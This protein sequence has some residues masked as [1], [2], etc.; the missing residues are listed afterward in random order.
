MLGSGTAYRAALALL[1]LVVL[2]GTLL[3]TATALTPKRR[4]ASSAV[5]LEAFPNPAQT[6][7]LITIRGQLTGEG[8]PLARENVQLEFSTEGSTWTSI[9]SAATGTDGRF[10]V[11]WKP[12]SQDQ[13]YLRAT[14]AGNKKYNSSISNTILEQINIAPPPPASAKYVGVNYV[15]KYNLYDTPA[16]ILNRDF[17]KFQADGIN[18]IVIVVYWSRLESARGI[19]NQAFVNDVIRVANIANSYGI[20]VMIDF[21]TLVGDDSAWSNPDY[22]GVGMNLITNP[23]IATAYIATVSWAVIQLKSVPNIWAYSVLNE[24]WSSPADWIKLIVD[25]SKAVKSVDNR[26]VTVRFV[27]PL[28]E[29]DFRWDS[30]LLAAVDFISLNAYISHE[31]VDD[32]YWNTWDEYKTALASTTQK[33]AALGKQIVI[34]EFGYADPNDMLQADY[35]R[36]YTEIFKSTRNLIGWLSWG[37]D[38]GD[39]LS[40]QAIGDYAIAAL[41]TGTPRPAYVVLVQNK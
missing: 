7:D 25:L 38:C 5:T 22:V 34:T 12:I 29:R 15:S 33:A 21:H 18:S 28:F 30:T 41:V 4:L 31:G 2:T 10:S 40:W 6:T 13:L 11:N 23:D 36:A 26:P 16:D 37:W 19:Y 35:Y 17:A 32:V 39:K 3:Q 9:T 1:L 27:A 24:P 20:Y 14:Y 8:T